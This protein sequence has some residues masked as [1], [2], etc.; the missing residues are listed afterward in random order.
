MNGHGGAR[1][2]AGRPV[3][4]VKKLGDRITGEERVSMAL[5][6]LLDAVENMARESHTIRLTAIQLAVISRKQEYEALVRL[7]DRREGSRGPLKGEG[8]RPP[9][10]PCA[11]ETERRHVRTLCPC[12]RM[13]VNDCAGECGFRRQDA[14]PKSE[15]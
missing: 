14:V 2:G 6:A 3:G 1:S 9:R 10:D 8:G 13:G 12:G 4:R 5:E 15:P 7:Y 11:W